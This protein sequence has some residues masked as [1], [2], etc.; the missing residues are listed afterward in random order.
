MPKALSSE[1]A[2]W[3]ASATAV[4]GVGA[5]GLGLI[6]T[7]ATRQDPSNAY[8]IVGWLLLAA[9]AL[10]A[11]LARKAPAWARTPLMLSALVTVA[12][13]AAVLALRPQTFFTIGAVIFFW[14]IARGTTML[15]SCFATQGGV[16]KGWFVFAASANVVLAAMAAGLTTSV[17]LLT[18]LFGPSVTLADYAVIPALSIALSGIARISAAWISRSQLDR[19]ID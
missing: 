9:A 14:L 11:M 8:S 16:A 6:M 15:A 1:V 17:G 19:K 4:S 12:T 18:L 10:D 2:P 5:V 7:F 3:P 13:A